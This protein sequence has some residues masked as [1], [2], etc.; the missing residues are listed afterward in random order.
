MKQASQFAVKR[1][2]EMLISG[3]TVAELKSMAKRTSKPYL[4]PTDE[5]QKIG[6]KTWHAASGVGGL[7]FPEFP[8]E[9]RL[10]PDERVPHLPP[11]EEVPSSQ[12]QYLHENRS[13]ETAKGNS[14]LSYLV[15]GLIFG[16]GVMYL[17]GWGVY[18]YSGDDLKSKDFYGVPYNSSTYSDGITKY[19]FFAKGASLVAPKDI[20]ERIWHGT[21]GVL[22][23]DNSWFGIRCKDRFFKRGALSWLCLFIGWSIIGAGANSAFPDDDEST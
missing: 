6:K 11:N 8:K 4:M 1:N 9:S 10:P 13:G 3:V 19:G 20:R 21:V 7:K 18:Y 2:G 12:N 23:N 17:G 16:L 22:F 15:W 5:I 14:K